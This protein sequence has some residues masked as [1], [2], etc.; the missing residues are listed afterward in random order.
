M[1]RLGEKLHTLR[2]RRGLS[3]RQLASMLKVKSGSHISEI[4]SGNR[5]PS[6]RL[7]C[8]IANL[9]NV[10]TDQL[11]QDELEVDGGLMVLPVGIMKRLGEKLR[12]LRKRQRLTQTQVA[13]MLEVDYTHVGK[14]ERGERK[15]GL[16]TL[17]KI[18][19]LFKVSTDLLV[20]DDLELE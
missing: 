2:D 8:K 20:L 14:M 15:P 10:T 6:L 5:R 12:T 17:A 13:E 9:F 1:Q 18:A 3:L 16:E 4:E 11:M 7:L 19:Q